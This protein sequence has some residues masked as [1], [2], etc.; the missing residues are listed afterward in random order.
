MLSAS[1]LWR[2]VN[3]RLVGLLVVVV[4]TSPRWKSLQWIDSNPSELSLAY[5]PRAMFTNVFFQVVAV[6]V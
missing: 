6:S 1:K 5:T 2:W 4:I 3:R